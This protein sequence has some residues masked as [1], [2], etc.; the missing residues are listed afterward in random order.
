[1][2]SNFVSGGGA[3]DSDTLKASLKQF[4]VGNSMFASMAPIHTFFSENILAGNF[5]HILR[6]HPAILKLQ[7]L[8]HDGALGKINYLYSNRLI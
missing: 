7:Q 2:T 1:L 6:Y 8:I 4:L 5:G 3:P